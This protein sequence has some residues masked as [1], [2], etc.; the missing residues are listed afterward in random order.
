M[1]N[2]YCYYRLCL[3]TDRLFDGMLSKMPLKKKVPFTIRLK[4]FSE[5]YHRGYWSRSLIFDLESLRYGHLRAVSVLLVNFIC[6]E[7]TMLLLL[8][9]SKKRLCYKLCFKHSN[10]YKYEFLEWSTDSCWDRKKIPIF[11]DSYDSFELHVT[12]GLLGYE[13]CCYDLWFL[14]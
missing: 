9:H 10:I 12:T 13:T 3:S 6:D 8:T 7:E 5:R 1:I 14:L 4:D 2:L 11:K